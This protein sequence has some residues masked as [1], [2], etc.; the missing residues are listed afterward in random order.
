MQRMLKYVDEVCGLV[1]NS[2]LYTLVLI[3][4]TLE[5]TRAAGLTAEALMREIKVHSHAMPVLEL[6][7]RRTA[8]RTQRH[9]PA[10]SPLQESQV[11]MQPMAV[12]KHWGCRAH[13]RGSNAEDRDVHAAH[14]C[15]RACKRA[16]VLL[17]SRRL[18]QRQDTCGGAARSTS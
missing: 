12:L 6:V 5:G 7:P 16:L 17:H 3:R 8:Q 1:P 13:H 2:G 14:A 9:F 11:H 4:C 10:V 18:T 15:T